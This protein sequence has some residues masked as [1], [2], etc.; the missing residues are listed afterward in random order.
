MEKCLHTRSSVGEGWMT[1]GGGLQLSAGYRDVALNIRIVNRE[2]IGMGV[3][4]HISEVSRP[5]S[6][7]PMAAFYFSVHGAL[8]SEMSQP[9]YNTPRRLAY[10]H[11][12][13]GPAHPSSLL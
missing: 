12:G 5:A 3:E 9:K 11:G 6:I 4:T 8:K 7:A 2:T 10:L 1:R 13:A